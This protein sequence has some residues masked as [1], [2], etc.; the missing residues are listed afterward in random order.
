M[1]ACAE[2]AERGV[3]RHAPRGDEE[4]DDDAR[5][6]GHAPYAV[7][8]D[9]PTLATFRAVLLIRAKGITYPADSIVEV[10]EEERVRRVVDWNGE[11]L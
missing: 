7:D 2:D 8:E 6:A 9:V 4:G 11:V 1:P 5:T 10:V 3:E